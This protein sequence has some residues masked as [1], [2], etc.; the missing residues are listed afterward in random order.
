[1]CVCA[2]VCVCVCVCVR[3]CVRV[4]ACVCVRVCVCVFPWGPTTGTFYGL[5]SP[6]YE[7]KAATPQLRTFCRKGAVSRLIP[8]HT[9][10]TQSTPWASMPAPRNSKHDT[11]YFGLP[12]TSHTQFARVFRAVYVAVVTSLPPRLLPETQQFFH[13]QL[14]PF[15][16]LI[17]SYTFIYTALF[18]ASK[19][20]DIRQ[21]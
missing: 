4:C 1:V 5:S 20:M 7:L 14:G 18:F 8:C 12:P 19:C 10:R 13:P 16:V 11:P 2:C 17:K 9:T 3:V 15:V 21:A 6:S